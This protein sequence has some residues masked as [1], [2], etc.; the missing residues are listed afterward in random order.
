M[1]EIE[2]LEREKTNEEVLEF[3]EKS[4]LIRSLD[5][6]TSVLGLDVGYV[7]RNSLIR[8]GGGISTCS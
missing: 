1:Q 7:V 2:E 4:L 3:G 8:N 5:L 6:Q